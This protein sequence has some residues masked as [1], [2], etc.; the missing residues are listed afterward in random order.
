M[1]FQINFNGI[2]HNIVH[3]VF[4]DISNTFENEIDSSIF[5]I[6]FTQICLV[7]TLDIYCHSTSTL[8]P[9]QFHYTHL[10][11]LYFHPNSNIATYLHSTSTLF[12]FYFH[13]PQFCM[14]LL[15]TYIHTCMT[16]LIVEAVC[17]LSAVKA[18]LISLARARL[19]ANQWLVL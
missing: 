19:R 2:S 18:C 13:C 4:A 9:S 14:V 17:T 6:I 15:T 5:K 7:V 16:M 1:I 3:V 12:L 11:P 10:L 8:L